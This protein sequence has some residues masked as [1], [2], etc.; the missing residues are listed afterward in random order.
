MQVNTGHIIIKEKDFKDEENIIELEITQNAN[1]DDMKKLINTAFNSLGVAPFANKIIAADVSRFKIPFKT[2][3]KN[4]NI[5]FDEDNNDV[6]ESSNLSG[7]IYTINLDKET[8][9]VTYEYNKEFEILYDH[10]LINFLE[11]I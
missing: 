9:K 11:Y 7:Y 8:I 6:F 3:L 2:D 10:K 1:I 4:I 5:K